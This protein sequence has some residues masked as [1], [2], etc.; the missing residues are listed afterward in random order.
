MGRYV[1]V[2]FGKAGKYNPETWKGTLEG[3]SR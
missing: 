3:M 2:E 1:F